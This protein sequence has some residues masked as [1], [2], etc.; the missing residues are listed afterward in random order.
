MTLDCFKINACISQYIQLEGE[1]YDAV[2]TVKANHSKWRL[3]GKDLYIKKY[4]DE[5]LAYSVEY[6]HEKNQVF[7]HLGNE[8]T[9]GSGRSSKVTTSI[10]LF[11]CEVYAYKKPKK[12]VQLFMGLDE[13]FRLYEQFK[14]CSNVVQVVQR[15][16]KGI[17]FE[18]MQGDLEQVNL[19]EEDPNT[20][21]SQVALGVAQVH[22]K[23]LVHRDI[24]PSNFLVSKD[25]V[26]GL[27]VKVGD[28]EHAI[29]V[30]SPDTR[31]MGFMAYCSL[32]LLQVR[33]GQFFDRSSSYL[34]STR[35]DMHALAV[36][37]YELIRGHRPAFSDTIYC[38]MS[39]L[40][41]GDVTREDQL[42]GP[43]NQL[44]A[45]VSTCIAEEA[46]ANSIVK[47][48]IEILTGKVTSA[49]GVCA[50]IENFKAETPL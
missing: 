38:L 16:H 15:T 39:L 13:D 18:Y 23:G 2:R 36:T 12:G 46:S 43:R 31:M 17:L 45:E 5:D 35:D 44:A 1:V 41:N 25:E 42:S 47:V 20:I 40:E 14:G 50:R 34:P 4:G 9:L 6:V 3:Q 10:E 21:I 27:V 30:G 22:E 19:T 7:L 37:I 49:E 32:E 26:N 11:S 28:L 29:R 48:A 8:A 24:R 33:I